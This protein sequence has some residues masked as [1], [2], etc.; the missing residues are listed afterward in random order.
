MK[1]LLGLNFDPEKRSSSGKMKGKKKYFQKKRA[2]FFVSVKCRHGPPSL[3]DHRPV[4]RTDARQGTSH[5]MLN[6]Y[7]RIFF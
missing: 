7:T 4:F 2:D 5:S 6:S 3:E 1:H